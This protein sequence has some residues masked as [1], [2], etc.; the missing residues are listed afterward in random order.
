MGARIVLLSGFLV[1]L[2][3]PTS[4]FAQTAADTD[5][6][7]RCSGPGVLRC[8]D[9]D[10]AAWIP[11]HDAVNLDRGYNFG[12]LTASP[13]NTTIDTSVKA[14]GA[15]S[16]HHRF[17]AGLGNQNVLTF[18]AHFQPCAG[19]GNAPVDCAQPFTTGA[20][21][22]GDQI[23]IQ[24]RARYDTNMLTD[25]NFLNA[26]GVPIPDSGF[27]IADLGLADLPTCQT[28]SHADSTNCPT[29]CSQQRFEL[30][31]TGS[32]D[33]NLIDSYVNCSGNQSGNYGFA[34]LHY[35]PDHGN[36]WSKQNKIAGCINSNGYVNCRHIVSPNQWY[37]FKLYVKMG[38]F[39]TFDNEVKF[40]M[41]TEGQPLEQLVNCSAAEPLKCGF[42]FGNCDSSG[43]A[44]N[45][46]PFN[47]VD[48]NTGQ[49]ITGPYQV[50]KFYL[51]P[52]MTN[53]NHV[54]NDA[55]VWYDELIISKQDIA[56]PGGSFP[57]RPREPTNVT[58]N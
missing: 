27:K 2:F 52:Y 22:A 6:Q 58:A 4:P 21:N 11:A 35:T 13:T 15:G 50:G 36:T 31:V 9:F 49:N 23:Y 54:V 17:P 38:H 43:C 3:L 47:L 33:T 48:S 5:F 18:F 42:E 8:V 44:N 30:V 19:A 20:L 45:G 51:L 55:N 28:G 29:T 24:W 14:S 25:S 40:W 41:G 7:S 1:S 26:S 57:V 37:T 12:L 10:S 34:G 39:N 56:D 53:L 46:I 32:A 16:L